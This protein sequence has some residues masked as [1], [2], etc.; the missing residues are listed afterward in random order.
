MLELQLFLECK[1]FYAYWSVFERR[2]HCNDCTSLMWTCIFCNVPFVVVDL[3]GSSAS[4]CTSKCPLF[5]A[6]WTVGFCHV[7]EVPKPFN[8][9]FVFM[10]CFQL[11]A[12]SWKYFTAKRA[13]S[14]WLPFARQKRRYLFAD[15]IWLRTCI[16]IPWGWNSW[17]QLLWL[18]SS[19]MSQW[20]ICVAQLL[21]D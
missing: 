17:R 3:E 7:E 18:M 16:F 4:Y 8:N 6:A 11:S 10:Y 21:P 12:R 19:K 1:C 20:T 15:A 9:F 5:L 13:R 14:K 2:Y